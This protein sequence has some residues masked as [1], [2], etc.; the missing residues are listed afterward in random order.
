MAD[1]TRPIEGLVIPDTNT[2]QPAGDSRLEVFRYKPGEEPVK[3]D[4]NQPVA[5]SELPAVDESGIV[6]DERQYHPATEPMFEKFRHKPVSAVNV[7][8]SQQEASK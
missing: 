1:G 3:T 2:Y 7:S 4:S 6:I 8:N 5:S